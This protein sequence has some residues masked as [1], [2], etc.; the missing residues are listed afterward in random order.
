VLLGFTEIP[1][2]LMR[3][4]TKGV[5]FIL[6]NNIKEF[7]GGKVTYFNHFDKR[8]GEIEGVDSVVMIEANTQNDELFWGLKGKVKELYR[9][10][11]A[12]SPR[13]M[14]QAVRE[15]FDVGREI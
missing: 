9:I 1:I 10:G 12:A 2:M 6:N 11:D 4:F 14:L 3:C 13:D 8:E 5:N 15:G 7:S